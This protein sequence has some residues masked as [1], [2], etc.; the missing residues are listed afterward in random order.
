M[1]RNNLPTV[2]AYLACLPEGIASYPDAAVKGSVLASR[3]NHP[4]FDQLLKDGNLP[5]PAV[6]LLRD[7]PTAT[8]WVPEVA[9]NTVMA[10]LYDVVFRENGGPAAYEEWSAEQNA[11][12]LRT[13]LYRILFAVVS[14]ERLLVAASARW[15]AFRRGTSVAVLDHDR[16][17]M[18]FRLTCPP[19]L[20]P[21]VGLHA[22][23]AA[24]RAATQA[25]G[26][27]VTV[28]Q[29]TAESPAAVR[30]HIEWV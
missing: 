27:R 5:E 29:W 17:T 1:P 11:R 4:G 3:R 25:A 12:L 21:P 9:F 30:W 14:P 13:P 16:S 26:G 6:R 20:Y 23:S 18:S 19:N 7:P 8:S 15:A 10:A 28:I 24:F 2:D 22:F